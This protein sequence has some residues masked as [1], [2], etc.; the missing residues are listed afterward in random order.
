MLLLWIAAAVGMFVAVLGGTVVARDLSLQRLVGDLPPEERSLRVDLIGLP[1][2][3]RQLHLD[4]VARRALAQLTDA[5]PIRVA[6]FRD[7]WLDGE[8][9]RVGGIDGHRDR[10]RL[11]SGRFPTRCDA[12]LCEVLQLGRSGKSELREGGIHLE[13]VGVAELRDP[14]AFGP[15]FTRLRQ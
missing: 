8:F 5:R 1:V 9:V 7:F 12:E 2:L 4:A 13:R 10:I 14:A 3:S 11:V 6:A 15:A